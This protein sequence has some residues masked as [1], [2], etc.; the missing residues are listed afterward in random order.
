M[1]KGMWQRIKQLLYKDYCFVVGEKHLCLQEN[2]ILLDIGGGG[3]Y[4]ATR[5]AKRVGM[6]ILADQFSGDYS[7]HLEMARLAA[8][9]EVNLHVI[10][11][12]AHCIPL[13]SSSVTKI[14]SNQILEH[15][16]KPENFFKEA[17][18]VLSPNGKL[19]VISQNAAF[20][21]NYHFPIQRLLK[22][23]SWL[24]SSSVSR[25]NRNRAPLLLHHNN[26]FLS[27]GYEAW[28]RAVGHIHRFT[29]EDYFRMA[30]EADLE[31]EKIYSIHGK[32]SFALWEIESAVSHS[33]RFSQ[34]IRLLCRAVFLPPSRVLE[35]FIGKEGVDLI[36]VFKKTGS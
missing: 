32:L 17:S 29:R 14:F 26:P 21:A 23:I 20:L 13:E 11:G 22:R 1:V 27:E 16:L 4:Y 5:L 33:R 3:G 6:L 25:G 28:E 15:L 9:T 30:K 35:G 12:D 18:R 34:P 10:C 8:E 36:G 24:L 2:D 31:V 7:F 19:I